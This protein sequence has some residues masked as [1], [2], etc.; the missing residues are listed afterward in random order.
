[1]TFARTVLIPLLAALLAAG[2]AA[3]AFGAGAGQALH[4]DWPEGKN[5]DG[6]GSAR[7]LN[8]VLSVTGDLLP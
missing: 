6:Y 1:M 5:A 8:R 7:Y 3:P 4:V 2:S